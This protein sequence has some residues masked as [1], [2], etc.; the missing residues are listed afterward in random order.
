[1]KKLLARGVPA[2]FI[3]LPKARHGQLPDA[4]RLMGEA[5]AWLDANARRQAQ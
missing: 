1:M 5:L 4:E 3:E 2:T